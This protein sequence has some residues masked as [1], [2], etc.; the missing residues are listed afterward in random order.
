MPRTSKPK[1]GTP[2]LNAVGKPFSPQYDPNYQLRHKPSYGHLRAP[3]PTTMRFV[4]DLPNYNPNTKRFF[5]D[6]SPSKLKRLQPVPLLGD[7][8]PLLEH[9][10]KTQAA[11]Q[12][13]IKAQARAL[14]SLKAHLDAAQKIFERPGLSDEQP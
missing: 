10:A 2:I 3:Y 7:H 6:V 1:T 13:Q 4:D 14:K 12:A 5:G 9:V 8:D 11:T